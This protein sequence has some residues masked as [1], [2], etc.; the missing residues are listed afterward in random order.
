MKIPCAVS[1]VMQFISAELWRQGI[2]F[3]SGQSVRKKCSTVDSGESYRWRF[4]S[5]S[6][7]AMCCCLWNSNQEVFCRVW[8]L[9]YKGRL[10]VENVDFSRRKRF[11]CYPWFSRTKNVRETAVTTVSSV[12]KSFGDH[13]R[14]RFFLSRIK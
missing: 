2:F 10:S 4:K 1:K 7:L 14:A 9:R 13:P 8:I 6:F 12:A 3:T 11:W 5:S